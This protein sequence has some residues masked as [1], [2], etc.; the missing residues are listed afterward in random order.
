MIPVI[1][2]LAIGSITAGRSQDLVKN[3]GLTGPLHKAHLG[4]VTFMAKPVPLADLGEKDLLKTFELREA[5][6]LNIRVFMEN[7]LIN[8]LHRL[9][10][11]KSVEELSAAGNY[12]FTFIV[13]GTVTY[14]ENLPPGAGGINGKITQTTY[15]VPLMSTTAEDSWGRFLWNRFLMSGGE[16]AFTAGMHELKIEIR[17]YIKSPDL[18]T[19]EI[20][21]SGR[22]VLKVVKPEVDESKIAPQTILPGSGWP[23]SADPFDREKIRDLKRK[24]AQ[25]DFKDITSLIVIKDGKLLIEE[26]FNGV[27]R[28]SLHNTRSV[29]KSFA[30]ALTGL[31]LRDGYIKN[32]DR[33]LGESYDLGAFAHPSPKKSSVT[34]RDLLTMSS[35]FGGSDQD[36]DSP[37]NEEKMYP[38]ADWVKFALDLPMDEAKENGKQWDYFTAGVVLLGDILDKVVPGG[39]ERYADQELFKP[40]GITKYEWQYTPQKVVNTAGGLALTALDLAK[41][42][43]LYKNGG[44]WDGRPVLPKSW[45]EATFHRYLKVPTRENTSY[46]LLF[47]NTTYRANGRPNETFFAT[48]NGGSKIYVFTDQPLVVVVTATAYGKSYA[49]PQVDKMMERYVLPAVVR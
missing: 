35:A 42:G 45:V 32:L 43:Q 18:K 16:D 38:T 26:Y 31:A 25:R 8:Y 10:P 11:G 17:P 39:L 6:D 1:L 49:H 9:A 27:G 36:M 34:L 19:G 14:T 28:T 23:V 44:L 46:G 24:I 4:E 40:L 21:A 20:I 30:S 41:F 7:S 12:Q 3:D 29:G 47:W 13:N 2:C 15:R 33:T 5:G 37:G 22:I 48:G